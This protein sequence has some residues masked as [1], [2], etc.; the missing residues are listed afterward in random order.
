MS[1]LPIE[2]MLENRS[3]ENLARKD[4]LHSYATIF[5]LKIYKYEGG[6]YFIQLQSTILIIESKVKIREMSMKHFV[7]TATRRKNN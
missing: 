7:Q 5:S 4:E 1:F 6:K 3:K 2:L